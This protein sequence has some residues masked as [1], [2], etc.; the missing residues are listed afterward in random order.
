MGMKTTPSVVEEES[1]RMRRRRRRRKG[2]SVEKRREAMLHSTN[3][4]II[5]RMII[6]G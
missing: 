3:T 4:P 1:R 2:K 5:F 6:Q